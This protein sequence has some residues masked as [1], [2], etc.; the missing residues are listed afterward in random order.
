MPVERG[1]KEVGRVTSVAW[2]PDSGPGAPPAGR[3]MGLAVLR[4]EVE[5]GV[6]VRTGGVDARVVP[7]PLALRRHD[8]A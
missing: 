8:P 3:W 1:E 7:L 4:R 6:M 2:V 5:P